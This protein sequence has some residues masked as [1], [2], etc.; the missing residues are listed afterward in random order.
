MLN[1][2]CSGE[3]YPLA[4]AA[5]QFARICRLEPIEADEID[6]LLRTLL[7]LFA[8]RVQRI[9]AK[10]DVLED[11][12]PRK[13]RECLEYNRDAFSRSVQWSSS[14]DDPARGRPYKPAGDSQQCRFARS[15]TAEQPEDFSGAQFEIDVLEDEHRFARALGKGLRYLAQID[16]GIICFSHSRNSQS[17]RMRRSASV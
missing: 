6:R 11:C 15:R 12:Q 13:Q 9:Q 7:G 4:H 5:G 8:A 2:D 3:G 10:L 14:I 16:D 1:G 17:S